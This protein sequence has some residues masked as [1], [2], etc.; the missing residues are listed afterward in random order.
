MQHSA[1][2][3][4]LPFTIGTRIIE[5]TAR[6]EFARNFVVC[7]FSLFFSENWHLRGQNQSAWGRGVENRKIPESGSERVCKRS[8][9]PRER[10]ASCASATPGAKQGCTSPM[11]NCSGASPISGLQKGPAE[12]GHVK[13]RQKVSK[14]FSTL[15]AQG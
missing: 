15:L 3:P 1:L 11:A 7:F 12:R 6:R 14:I 10:K 4:G 9:E 5:S 2:R 13:K 8:Y